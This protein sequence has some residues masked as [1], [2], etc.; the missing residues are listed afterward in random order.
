MHATVPADAQQS[1]RPTRI[2]TAKPKAG[3]TATRA[4]TA[5]IW[6]RLYLQNS[7]SADMLLKA[8]E[9]FRRS[10]NGNS[11]PTMRRALWDGHCALSFE[12]ATALHHARQAGQLLFC[13][14]G[15]Q[16]VKVQA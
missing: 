4:S 7:R 13:W 6:P 12:A 5:L 16:A 14:D 11:R 1:S 10:I 2:R 9:K 8:Y 3:N 15:T